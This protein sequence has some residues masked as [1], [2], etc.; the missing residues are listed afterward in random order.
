MAVRNWMKKENSREKHAG[1]KGVFKAAAR[2][3]GYGDTFEYAHHVAADPNASTLQKERANM[4]LRYEGA[5]KNRK[6]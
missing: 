4:A 2:R 5:Q 3:A 1:T 6:K